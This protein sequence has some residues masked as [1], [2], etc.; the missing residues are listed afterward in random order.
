MQPVTLVSRRQF[1]GFRVVFGTYLAIH[2]ASLI[3]YSKE[4]FSN[5]GVLPEAKFNFTFGVLP[6]VLEHCDLPAFVTGFLVVLVCLSASFAFG[7]YRRTAAVLLWYGWACLFNRNNL[8]SNPSIPYVGLLLLL[9]TLVPL[10]EGFQRP[11][12]GRNWEFPPMVFWT[13][14][15]LL[16][17]GYS[18]SG[19][20]KLH[21]P[22]WIDGS[23]LYHVMNNPLARPG[24]ARDLLLK[25]PRNSLRLLTWLSLAGE[26]LCLPLSLH[27]TTRILAWSFL[28]VMNLTILLV[29]NFSD[30]TIG[31]LMIHLFTFDRRW[32]KK[33]TPKASGSLIQ[34]RMVERLAG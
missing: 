33:S 19:W 15:I 18:F 28:A 9:T 12:N 34:G 3:P 32:L 11:V 6:N 27:R 8:I 10:G 14:W 20:M 1:A 22:S 25:I 29:I 17:A 16:A 24:L 7:I 2:F 23:A 31:M 30:L 21:S 26:V 5:C 13:A 4:L